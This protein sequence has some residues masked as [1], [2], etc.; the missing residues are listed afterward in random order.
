VHKDF[1]AETNWAVGGKEREHIER[2]KHSSIRE[3]EKEL[4]NKDREER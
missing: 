1:S 4:A 3:I 2:A